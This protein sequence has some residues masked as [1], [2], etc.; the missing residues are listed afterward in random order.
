[1][2]PKPGFEAPSYVNH[3]K[4]KAWVSEVA[5]LT[6]PDRIYWCDGSEAEY[7]QLCNEM[8][9]SGMLF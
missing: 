2:M 9:A 8:V 7:D 5:A 4:L 1:M 3:A 6:Q